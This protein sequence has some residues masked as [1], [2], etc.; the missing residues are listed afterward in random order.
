MLTD[1]QRDRLLFLA[2]LHRTVTG[3]SADILNPIVDRCL[4]NGS[5]EELQELA[6]EVRRHAGQELGSF[7]SFRLEH[8]RLKQTETI[9]IK[10]IR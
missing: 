7:P 1:A 6:Q 8:T 9:P 10:R 5:P 4:Q 3:E 2:A